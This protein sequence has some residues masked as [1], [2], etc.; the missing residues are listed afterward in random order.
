MASYLTPPPA[1]L[2]AKATHSKTDADLRKVIL[3]G[4]PGTAMSGFQGVFDEVQVADL[5][6][7][8]RS[9]K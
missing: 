2:I 8:I 4:R 5:L 1:N 7:Y 9:L 3:E 6:A